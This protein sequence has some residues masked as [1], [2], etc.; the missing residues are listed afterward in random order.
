[1]SEVWCP[2]QSARGFQFDRGKNYWEK[3]FA[4]RFGIAQTLK[5]D[6]R[7]SEKETNLRKTGWKT[8][9]NCLIDG[10]KYSQIHDNCRRSPDMLW[11]IDLHEILARFLLLCL[12]LV[13][14]IYFKI[15]L[16]NI[17]NDILGK[18]QCKSC[19]SELL[20]RSQH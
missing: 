8:S 20:F 19:A 16:Q 5:R 14:A 6:N 9:K 17:S 13:A 1:M 2:L 7:T 10:K 3:N 4:Y 18:N 15:T 12:L 11:F